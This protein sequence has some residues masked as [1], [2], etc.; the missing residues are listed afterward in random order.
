MLGLAIENRTIDGIP[1]AER[2]AKRARD[3]KLP[4]LLRNIAEKIPTH[5]VI[6][7]VSTDRGIR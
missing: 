1:S 6:F 2:F 7:D 5:A 4:L 3:K